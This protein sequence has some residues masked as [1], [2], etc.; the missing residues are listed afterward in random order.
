MLELGSLDEV[1]FFP[2]VHLLTGP[3]GLTRNGGI[4]R[5]IKASMKMVDQNPSFMVQAMHFTTYT[6][7]QAAWEEWGFEHPIANRLIKELERT[8]GDG[9]DV[10]LDSGGFQL[11]H[12]DKVDLSKWN[13]EMNR[14]NILELQLKYKPN[15]IASLDSPISPGTPHDIARKLQRISI[16]NAAW[17]VGRIEEEESKPR[18]YLAVHGRTPR[19][20]S[21]Y[22]T[23]LWK[24]IPDRM[25]R[26][27]D[28][29]LAL[30][31]QVPLSRNRGLISANISTVL[32]WMNRKCRPEVPL[33]VF[34]AGD[35]L[36]GSIVHRQTL[37]REISFDNSTY[38]QSAFRLKVYD[39][40]ALAYRQ[41]TPQSLP[42]CTCWACEKLRYLGEKSL[43]EIMNFPAYQSHAINGLKVS[44][45]EVFAYIALH[46]MVW[47]KQRIKHVDRNFSTIPKTIALPNESRL[48]PASYSFPLRQFKPESRNLL[49]LPC[50]HGRPYSKSPKQKRVIRYLADIGLRENIDY[51]RITVS[52]LFG[53]VHWKDETLPA[54]LGYDYELRSTATQHHI[55][56]LRFALGTTLN[57]IRKK[58][59]SVIGYL[60]PKI[61]LKTFGP[62]IQDFRGILV[63]DL[64]EI[65][66]QIGR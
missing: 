46:N 36:I 43:M 8:F 38:A 1:K 56:N 44:R 59:D 17:L 33:H 9:R 63:S 5:T 39:P 23:K 50:T 42:E 27:V 30:G 53:P 19:E 55:N 52:G 10:F 62:V 40:D 45:S 12:S 13:L 24:S 65:P 64:T 11:L 25:F 47:W 3:P 20:V 14:E 16:D 2:V 29:G 6:L 4:W 31:S 58:Y 32:K 66:S 34:G 18:V 37:G 57:V 21:A 7:S 28:F 60:N 51:D 48:T 54:I 26:D 35:S 49:I 41:W 15:R 61:Y 22:L